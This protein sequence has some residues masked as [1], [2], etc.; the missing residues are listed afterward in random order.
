MKIAI[1]SEDIYPFVKGGI[2]K[3]YYEIGRRLAASGHEIHWFGMKTWT[4]NDSIVVDN[5]HV[6]AVCDRIEL[7][8]REGRRSIKTA[9][10][11]TANVLKVLRRERLETYDVIDCALYPFFHCFVTKLMSRGTP[12]VITWVEFWGR[13]WY[14][15]LGVPGIFGM[16]V[17]KFATKLPARIIAVSDMGRE[18]LLR[19]GVAEDNV[20]TVPLGIEFEHIDDIA[21]SGKQSDIV[22][23]GGLRRHKNIDVLIR[24]I[25]LLTKEFP[26]INAVIIGDGPMRSAL[27]DLTRELSLE[28]NIHFLGAVNSADEMMS[29]VKS[30]KVFVHPSTKEGGG[31][32]TLLE[33]SACGI[34]TIAVK[35]P[36]GIDGR[37]ITE[38]VNGFWVDR[39]EPEAIAQKIKPILADGEF[40]AAMK[41]PCRRFA[42]SFDWSNVS[43]S[44]EQV[45]E[46]V[47][48]HR[49][50]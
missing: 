39:L 35:H 5:I 1:I 41:D 42:A 37:L 28:N 3:R 22:Y 14:E 19:A 27:E 13:H 31:S 25:K 43:E 2:Q 40:A 17:E 26:A 29:L 18:D 49:Q 9:L 16:A 48:R 24:A 15:Y 47:V 21:A 50:K 12:V 11:F 20:I 4:G 8:A 38:G 7:F 23:F 36:L 46:S 44:V 45:Y 32:I 6:H 33:A 30:S 10:R 34:P